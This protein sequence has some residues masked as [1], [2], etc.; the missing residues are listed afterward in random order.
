MNQLRS[1]IYNQSLKKK[2]DNNSNHIQRQ[3]KEQYNI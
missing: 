3:L 2:I 1:C